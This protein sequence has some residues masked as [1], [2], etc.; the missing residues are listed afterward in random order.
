M[1]KVTLFNLMV[2]AFRYWYFFI[3]FVYLFIGLQRPKNTTPFVNG[4][5]SYIIV[6]VASKQTSDYYIY[7]RNL[8]ILQK[9]YL[10]RLILV[11]PVDKINQILLF[12][13]IHTC[14]SWQLVISGENTW[15]N[16]C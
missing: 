11:V 2:L 15:G 14:D 13:T 4:Q 5:F 3:Y 1:Y 8:P 12:N 10:F 6:Y 7:A 16:S 9:K